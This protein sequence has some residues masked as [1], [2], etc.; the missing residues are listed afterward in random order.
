MDP[1]SLAASIAGLLS[2]AGQ[3]ISTGYKLCSKMS[4]NA[5]DLK[6]LINEAAGFSGI[7][8]G[9]KSHL[10][11]QPPVLA[12]PGLMDKMLQDS[13]TTL[14]EL[15]QLLDKMSKASR[16]AMMV[17]GEGREERLEKLLRRI[18]Q[19]KLFFI[20]CFQLEHSQGQNRI[21]QAIGS[22]VDSE[23]L[24]Q[25]ERVIQWL[26]PGTDTEHEDLCKRRDSQSAE[27]ILD[28]T[29]FASW[30]SSGGSS[31]LWLNGILGSLIGQLLRQ[32]SNPDILMGPIT[33]LYEK[34]QR[35]STRPSLEDLQ[36]IFMG[37]SQYFGRL[38]LVFDGLDEV[39]DRWSILEFLENLSQTDGDFKVLVASRAEMDLENAFSFYCTVTVTPGDIRPDIERFVRKQLGRRRFR[40][41]EVEEVVRELVARADGMF[42]WVVCQVDHLFHVRTAITPK[43][44]QSLPR[45]L[46]RTFEQTFLKLDSEDRVLAKRI[47][48]FVMLSSTPLDLSELVEG[49]AISSKTASLDDV[50]RNKLVNQNDVFEICGSLIRESQSTGKIELAHYSVY[51]FLKSLQVE[52]NRENVL[53]LH[54]ADGNMELLLACA[55]YLNMEDVCTTGLPV[56]VEESLE[57]DDTYFNP[58]MFANTPFLEHAASNW[59]VYVSRLEETRLKVAWD[60]I[61][62]TFFQPGAGHFDFWAKTARYIH[63]QHKYPREMTP[64]HATAVHGLSGLAKLLMEDASLQT[65]PWKPLWA[66]TGSRTPLHLAIEN[67]QDK[68]IEIFMI[69]HYSQSTDEQGR[70][71]LHVALESANE[72]AV[73]QLVSAG[74]NVN[75]REKDGRTPIFIAIENT[76]EDLASLLSKMADPEITMPDG[77]GLLHLVAQTGSTVWTSSLI[78][79]HDGLINAEDQRGWT[80]LLYAVDG[81][82]GGVVKKLLS[83]GA[84]VGVPDVNGWT[85][86][87]AAMRYQYSECAHELLTSGNAKLPPVQPQRASLQE[88]YVPPGEVSGQERARM[89]RKYGTAPQD[90]T[91]GAGG[92][93]SSQPAGASGGRP[94]SSPRASRASV[95]SVPSPMFLAVSNNFVSGVELLLQ[96]AGSYGEGEVG[97]LETDG[98]CLKKALSLADTAILE[99]LLPVSTVPSI[100]AVLPEMAAREDDSAL[101]AMR[102][103][104]GIDLVH[105]NLLPLSVSNRETDIRVANFLL[106][107]WTPTG[108]TLPQNILHLAAR[109]PSKEGLRFVSRLVEGGADT[110]YTDS[111]NQTPLQAAIRSNNWDVA[112]FFAA[113]GMIDA[114]VAP[115]LLHTVVES[116]QFQDDNDIKEKVLP[117]AAMC[118]DSGVDIEYVDQTGRSICHRAAMRADSILLNWALDNDAYPA[119]T[120]LKG[121][122]AV[123]VAVAFARVENLQLLLGSIIQILP[124][125]L[126]RILATAGARKPPLMLATDVSNVPILT[127]LIEAD[128]LAESLRDADDDDAAH[129]SLRSVIFTNALCNAIRRGFSSGITLLIDAM[130]DVSGLSSTGET[131]LHVAVRQ[132]RRDAVKMLLDRGAQ[133]S[134]QVA[135][136]GETPYSIAAAESMTD[137]MVMLS[138]HGASCRAEDIMTAATS[139]DVVL[140]ESVL[141]T[142]PDDVERQTKALFTARRLK[143]AEVADKLLAKA[144]SRPEP[145]LVQGIPRDAYGDTTLHQ[146]VRSKDAERIRVLAKDKALLKAKDIGGDSALMLAIRNCH[147]GSAEILARAGGDIG[148]ALDRAV[149]ER[150]DLWV[151]KLSDL[152]TRYTTGYY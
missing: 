21:E 141:A 75:L 139:G 80:P 103:K 146:A 85:P 95:V 38:F 115:D 59:S 91:S 22:L 147:W 35:T 88:P 65:A 120:D 47:L 8:L 100:L 84:Y 4:K 71:P 131:P 83:K 122:T 18:E 20:L 111:E 69:S 29:E 50:R 7:L 24:K 62:L 55:R 1:L 104:L 64:L 41:S 99:M 90:S 132:G 96:H 6:A 36:D 130:S 49:I 54:E 79:C 16:L 70:T 93:S 25:R 145:R 97:L 121:D 135:D 19:H 60:S 14:E 11:S 124:E 134:A 67:G 26:G 140:L 43:L 32:A 89:R 107:V 112:H 44:L 39:P 45:N 30:L 5:D 37:L 66:T 82:L 40:G 87:H 110:L 148:E 152:R 92:G 12:D 114:A 57:D 48:Q 126:V 129:Q 23:Q 123:H 119:V 33:K 76:W 118:L 34:H 3:V 2:L 56:E 46:E 106:D 117:I 13:K 109:R 125:E 74:A 58:E 137:I 142:Y 68:M 78:A 51:L 72:L 143:Q 94:A 101:I 31:F 73:T 136:T 151:E 116:A 150:C 86:L 28:R 144:A 52:G 63:G 42:L 98:A 15:G 138:E 113:R 81:G 61:L 133:I 105:R 127:A 17:K 149:A 102:R 27:W 108:A 128:Q 10:Q 53:Y 77:R 9:V